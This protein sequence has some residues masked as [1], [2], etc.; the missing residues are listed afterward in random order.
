MKAFDDYEIHGVAEFTDVLGK[1]YCEQVADEEAHFWSL[2]GRIPGQGLECIGDF[3]TRQLAEEVLARITR[4]L[5]AAELLDALTACIW[6]W[7]TLPA[8]VRHM[9]EPEAF[10]RGRT[11][12][13]RAAAA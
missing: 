8:K 2:Y 13:S 1:R 4:G 11:L 6:W 3:K 9:E 10:V 7:D 12:I 5:S